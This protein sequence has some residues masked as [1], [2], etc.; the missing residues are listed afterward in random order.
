MSEGPDETVP[1]EVLAETPAVVEPETPT[2]TEETAE[3][4]KPEAESEKTTEEKPKRISGYD[5]MKRKNQYLQSEI[6]RLQEQ[7][8]KPA[9]ETD[10]A[11]KE[12]DF[13][14]DWGK[15]I[16]ATAAYEAAKAV[17]GSL[18]ADRKTANEAKV[19]ELRSEILS[20]FEER[21][22]AFKA[23]ATDFED[24][25]G[26]YVNKGG[27]FSDVI[28]ELVM[29]SDLGPQ[30]TYHL[31]KNP[32]V[33]NKLNSLSPL[34]AAKEFARLEDTLSKPSKVTKAP[35]PITSPKGGASGSFDPAKASM[36]EYVAKRKA[37]WGS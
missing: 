2:T 16:A 35:A 26:E 1:T 36:D 28:R 20:E 10:K 4:E 25:I 22:E 8:S 27:K 19:A 30:L 13:G 12:E 24:V 21:T 23:K 17:K 11:P 3:G 9:P 5:R 32:A 31:A 29:E 15:Y 14:G 18:D 7:A 37:G 33:A 6:L 34:Q